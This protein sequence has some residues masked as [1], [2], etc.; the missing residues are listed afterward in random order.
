[1]V[2]NQLST[3]TTLPLPLPYQVIPRLSE[4]TVTSTVEFSARSALHYRIMRKLCHHGNSHSGLEDLQP[5][6]EAGMPADM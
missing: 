1:M 2:L 6:Y 5:K 3:G 4:A